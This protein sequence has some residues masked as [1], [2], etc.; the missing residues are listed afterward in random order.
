MGV[1]LGCGYEKGVEQE[2]QASELLANLFYSIHLRPQIKA[3]GINIL[4][5]VAVLRLGM[6]WNAHG[7][8]EGGGGG[9]QS[10]WQEAVVVALLLVMSPGCLPLEGDFGL[11]SLT[12]CKDESASTESSKTGGQILCFFFFLY[13]SRVSNKQHISTEKTC[14][15]V[16]SNIQE[17]EGR[18]IK[19]KA[20]LTRG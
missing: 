20:M 13:T 12:C 11:S 5:R 19:Q 1:A 3:A 18:T 7:V 10:G 17:A 14:S 8:W 6:G 15:L 9:S 4:D 2:G 16:D